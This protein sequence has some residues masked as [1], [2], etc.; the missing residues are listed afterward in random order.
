MF[1]AKSQKSGGKETA[2]SWGW[3]L[4]AVVLARY[5]NDPFRIA[6]QFE[7]RVVCEGEDVPHFLTPRLAVWEGDTRTIRLFLQPLRRQF[8][9]EDFGMRFTCCHEIF[10]GLYACGGDLGGLQQPAL[11]LREQEQAAEAF[12]RAMI[13]A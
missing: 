7:W 8:L 11:N 5:G 13:Y 2:T 10:H 4:A 6:A 12:A 1:P 3:R 9:Q